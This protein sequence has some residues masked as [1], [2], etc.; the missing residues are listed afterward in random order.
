MQKDTSLLKLLATLLVLCLVFTITLWFVASFDDN[1]ELWGQS[2]DFYATASTFSFY[3]LV[4]I[5]V[6]M[7]ILFDNKKFN[8][9]TESIN[10]EEKIQNE[11]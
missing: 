5:C 11:S 10:N 7:I 8:L 6:F 4:L 9:F 1:D 3:L 2:A